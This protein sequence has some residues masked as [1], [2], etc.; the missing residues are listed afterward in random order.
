MP[1]ILA[2]FFL[3]FSIGWREN[4]LMNKKQRRSFVYLSP[5]VVPDITIDDVE[6]VIST[7]QKVMCN[8]HIS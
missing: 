7:P 8:L 6:R 5:Q 1:M 3:K 2:I 4:S